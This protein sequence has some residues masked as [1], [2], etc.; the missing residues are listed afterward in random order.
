MQNK[1]LAPSLLLALA[2]VGVGTTLY[3][4]Y[5]VYTGNAPSCLLVGCEKVLA[6]EY[7]KMFGVPLSY[8]GLVYFIYLLGLAVLLLADPRSHGLR[9]G[10]TLYTGLGV[11][12]FAHAIFYVQAVLIGA[13]C[14]YCIIS[15]LTTLLAF[16]VSVWD[17]QKSPK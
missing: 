6:S 10:A 11:L 8:L 17:F 7:S 12:Y 16:G 1:L 9:L 3:L 14:Q 5:S 2:L 13:F 15:A 4:S